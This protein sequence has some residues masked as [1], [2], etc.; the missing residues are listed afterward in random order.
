[1]ECRNCF[2]HIEDMRKETKCSICNS[3]IHKDCAIKENNTFFCDVCYTVKSEDTIKISDSIII[4][5]T[6]RRSYIETYKAC[7]YKFYL[8]VI[9]GIEE[10]ESTI[11]AQIGI[12]LHNLFDKASQDRSYSKQDMFNEFKPIW[13]SYDMHLFEDQSQKDKLEQRYIDSIN[14]FYN[15]LPKLPV[16]PFSTE[17]QI[18]FSIGDDLPKISTTSDRIDEIDGELEMIDWK[19]GKTMV[20]N[21]LSSDLQAPLYIYGAIQKYQRPIR[22]FTFYY[23]QENKERIFNRVNTDNYVCQVRNRQYNINLTDAIREVQ[24]IFAQIKKNNF[25]IPN[26]V[27]KMYFTC[28]MCY[29]QKN[30]HCKGA[31]IQSWKMAQGV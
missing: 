2:L 13:N 9:K 10:K 25:N 8:E 3:P 4:P 31:D 12:D 29:L 20:G 22:K 1:M 11:Y 24:A 18:V 28:K 6:I 7:P 14:A 26:D 23:L 21:K 27:K 15:I 16:V 30:G 5:D 19:T 17:N